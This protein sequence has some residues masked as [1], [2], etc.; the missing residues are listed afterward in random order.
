MLQLSEKKRDKLIGQLSKVRKGIDNN[1]KVQARKLCN[2]ITKELKSLESLV[3]SIGQEPSRT[4]EPQEDVRPGDVEPDDIKKAPGEIP[5]GIN[6]EIEKPKSPVTEDKISFPE[7]DI[8]EEAKRVHEETTGKD[9]GAGEGETINPEKELED[10][11]SS[12]NVSF[13]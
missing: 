12:D 13:N 11:D 5:K 1:A 6:K 2:D 10:E 8:S 9:F 4:K 7:D 3:Q